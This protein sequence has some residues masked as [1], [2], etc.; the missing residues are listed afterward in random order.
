MK[1]TSCKPFDQF[2]CQDLAIIERR[3]GDFD[4][5][6]VKARQKTLASL[7]RLQLV[8]LNVELEHR[9]PD[10]IARTDEQAEGSKDYLLAACFTRSGREFDLPIRDWQQG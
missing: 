9:G 10:N 4:K 5:D 6:I 7:E 1:V 2:S 3:E 8:P